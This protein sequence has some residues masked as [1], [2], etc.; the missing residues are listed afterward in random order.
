MVLD[1]LVKSADV[2]MI[3]SNVFIFSDVGLPKYTFEAVY[4]E[5]LSMIN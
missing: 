3:E 5:K 4:K 1:D 2:L